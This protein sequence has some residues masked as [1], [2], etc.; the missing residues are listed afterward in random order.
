M[1][2]FDENEIVTVSTAAVTVVLEIR[3]NV[4][5]APPPPVSN[6]TPDVADDLAVRICPFVPTATLVRD[7][8]SVVRMSPLALIGDRLISDCVGIYRITPI[9]NAQDPAAR[10]GD[11][12]DPQKIVNDVI[13]SRVFIDAA[14]T[15]I[16][17]LCPAVAEF[18]AN[19]FLNNT[20]FAFV[21]LV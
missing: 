15:V 21:V 16:A 19:P 18:L 3:T 13:A 7:E 14:P 11:A 9:S 6:C 8:P 17:P 2:V 5:V 12:T 1:L 10:F 20:D 4:G